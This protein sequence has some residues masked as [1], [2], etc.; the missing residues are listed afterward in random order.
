MVVLYG[1]R[2]SLGI[3]GSEDGFMVFELELLGLGCGLRTAM[4][5][6]PK[7]LLLS[8]LLVVC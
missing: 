4:V 8:S 7:V 1:F 3:L 6:F 2:D 5:L